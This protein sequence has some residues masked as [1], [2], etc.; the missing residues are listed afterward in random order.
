MLLLFGSSAADVIIY[1]IQEAR[2]AQLLQHGQPT[3]PK[4]SHPD[5]LVK[6]RAYIVEADWLDIGVVDSRGN[7]ADREASHPT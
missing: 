5:P 3:S 7:V 6:G 4:R 2:N 1:T